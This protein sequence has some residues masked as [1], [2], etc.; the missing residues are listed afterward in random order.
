MALPTRPL[1]KTGMEITRVG[2]GSWAAGGGGWAFS[3]GPQD[4]DQSIAAIR[5]AVEAGI[6]WVD[7]A[8]GY[9]QGHS[10]EVVA[11]AL[12]DIPA[13]DRP[14]VFTK[15][16][17]RWDPAEPYK[18]SRRVGAPSSIREE[19]EQSLRRLQ[20]DV[21][22]L[23]QMHWP[24]EDGTPLE[25]Y[26]QAL[27]Q[28]KDE[29]KIRAAAL[30]NH[31]TAQLEAAESLG[32]VESLQPPF[33]AIKRTS[34]PE[35]AWCAAHSAGVIVYSPMQAGLLTG[36]FS[37]ERVASLH[38]DDWRGRNAE[39][40]GER[41]SRNLALADALRAIAEQK[42]TSLPALAVAWAAAWPGVTG[43]IVGARSAAQVDGWLPAA[44]IELTPT[45]LEKVAS[46]IGTTGAG[47]GP[48]RPSAGS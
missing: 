27:L 37:A 11:R 1:G 8:P 46:A 14:Y 30:C 2:F 34:A 4:D 19:A 44:T 36:R 38:P 31:G 29:G 18:V 16:G 47:D 48:A 28:L 6:N 17:L 3:W 24:A 39:F 35:I 41:L 15:C 40:Q 10:E 26:W 9:G 22:D 12:R 5:H 42:G 33:S 7:T 45:D 20:V 32:H 23:Y 21:I 13:P 25:S 43:A